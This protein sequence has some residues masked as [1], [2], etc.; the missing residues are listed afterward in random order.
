MVQGSSIGK[1]WERVENL[2]TLTLWVVSGARGQTTYLGLGR[3]EWSGD[4]E[5]KIHKVIWCALNG[6]TP[7]TCA[8]IFDD[9]SCT[10]STLIRLDSTVFFQALR[11]NY[12]TK[13]YKNIL[14]TNF[15]SHD[16]NS[17]TP[18]QLKNQEP[19]ETSI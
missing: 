10:F 3:S 8:Q 15:K 6:T 1:K 2:A 9:F 13:V 11:F 18:Q 17:R 7:H 5:S 19:I 14:K 16:T 12:P 4:L